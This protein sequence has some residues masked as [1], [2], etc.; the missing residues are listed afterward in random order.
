[1]IKA[2]VLIVED[3]GLVAKDIKNRLMRL[4]Y[5]VAAIVS[6]GE[7][8]VSKAEELR[9]DLILMDIMLRGR[10][11]GIEAADI[12][13]ASFN[14]PVLFLTAYSDSKT[15]ERAK[16]TEP[17]GY[18]LKPFD[19]RELHI[20]VEMAIYKHKIEMR[21]KEREQWLSITLKSIGDAL[22]ATDREGRITFMNLVALALTGW[23]M[24]EALGK[25]LS[26]VVRLLSK[27]S[28]ELIE[29]PADRAMRA[30]GVV[31]LPADTILV[32]GKEVKTLTE[33]PLE[34]N[35]DD[36]AAP[37]KNKKGEIV[38]SVLIFR[39]VTE[40]IR[41]E[42]KIKHQAYHDPLTGL[43]N[44]LL[45]HDRL[46]MS[47]FDAQRRKQALAVVFI[48]LDGFKAVND[49]LG[50]YTGDLL[51]K[52]VTDRLTGCTRQGDTVARIGGDEFTLA[53]PNI[54]RKEEAGEIVRRHLDAIRKG[55]VINGHEVNIS[56]SA[57]ISLFHEDGDDIQTLMKKA[58]KAMYLAKEAGKN[59]YRFYNE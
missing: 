5:D 34:I 24:E 42:E 8:A 19:E 4:G 33:I 11:D 3:E 37:I 16:I 35:I 45:F 13:R 32:P 2:S 52:S 6:T 44:R 31:T 59:I 20:T 25:H 21:L 43:P 28:R 58:D 47:L 57:G 26:E 30:G 54:T 38:G 48:D 55:F 29:C 1:M 51:L 40:R 9:P 7:E 15:L 53:L 12:I 27:N 41:E 17:Y 56:A 50:H 10:M 22:V 46:S 14:I 36:S 23:E 49:T 39:D 18:I